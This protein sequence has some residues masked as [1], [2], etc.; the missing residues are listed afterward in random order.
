[1]L[2]AGLDSMPGGGAEIFQKIQDQIAGGK[3]SGEQ[4]LDIIEYGTSWVS[5]PMLQCFMVMLKS[6]STESII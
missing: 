1:M 6:L 4:W 3:C 5:V 2:D